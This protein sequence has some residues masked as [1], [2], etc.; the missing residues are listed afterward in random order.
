MATD[1]NNEV[2][3]AFLKTIPAVEHHIGSGTSQSGLWWVEYACEG[4]RVSETISM[5]SSRHAR[6]R[7][8]VFILNLTLERFLP[9]RF[10]SFK[11]QS[12]D[13]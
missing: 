13:S 12:C 9:A 5:K 1:P 11:L 4:K 7:N 8:L 6:A 10:L 2:L 3:I